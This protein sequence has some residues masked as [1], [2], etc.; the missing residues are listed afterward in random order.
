M[1][2]R[3]AATTDD[4]N[5]AQANRDEGEP[6]TED[7]TVEERE[8]NETEETVTQAET[9]PTI[10]ETDNNANETAP[11]DSEEPSMLSSSTTTTESEDNNRLPMITL[12]RTFVL[13]FFASLIPETP[14]V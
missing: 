7:E 10:D 3:Q 2:E 5:G 6:N 8:M 9:S 1:R 11:S 13:S 12:I 4:N 14:A